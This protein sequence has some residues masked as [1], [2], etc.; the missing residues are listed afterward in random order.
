M[1][2]VPQSNAESI[3]LVSGELIWHDDVED[4][5]EDGGVEV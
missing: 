3:G 5:I 4:E 2:F 1:R